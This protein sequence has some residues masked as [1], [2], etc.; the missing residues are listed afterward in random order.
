MI[1]H[2]YACSGETLF[3][4]WLYDFAQAYSG[5]SG[6]GGILSIYGC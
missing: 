6:L 5:G 1:S 2:S 3:I 4:I